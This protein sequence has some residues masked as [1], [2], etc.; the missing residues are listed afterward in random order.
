M[1]AFPFIRGLVTIAAAALLAALP[2][3]ATAAGTGD[4]VTWGV[5]P[6]DNDHGS[7]RTNFAYNGDPGDT[8][9]DGFVITNFSDTSQTFDVYAADAVTTES[10]ALDLLPAGTRSSDVGAWVRVAQAPVRVDPGKSML[11]PFRIVIPADAS[12]GD[13]TGGVVSALVSKRDGNGIEVERRLGSRVQIR[14]GGMLDPRVSIQDSSL[15]Y[16]MTQDP[17]GTSEATVAYTVVN[18]GNARLRGTQRITVTGPFGSFPASVAAPDLPDLLPG[19]SYD[20]RVVVPGVRPSGRLTAT[21][22]VTP[23]LVP[24]DPSRSVPAVSAEV[25]AWA[26]PWLPV[27][28]LAL[29]LI[30]AGLCARRLL[31]GRHRRDPV[32]A[33]DRRG[34]VAHIP[35][36][37][38]RSPAARDA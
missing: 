19:S 27:A 6:A 30:V 8:I 38:R 18:T 12:P 13:H 35:E 20:V 31:S 9:E 1:S 11:V 5:M 14:V 34:S 37:G 3:P 29:L 4:D 33:R 16:S 7:G 32:S 28:F 22:S 2:V 24:E 17:F 21:I 10:G 26:V 23:V 15:S 25:T 36:A